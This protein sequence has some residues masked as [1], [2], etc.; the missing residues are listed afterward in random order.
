MAGVLDTSL[1]VAVIGATLIA[2]S[3]V[4][5][6]Y[7]SYL[8]ARDA[9]LDN[10]RRLERRMAED[11]MR[12]ELQQKEMARQEAQTQEALE[13]EAANRR[14]QT[15]LDATDRTYSFD[16]DTACSRRSATT[17]KQLASCLSGGRSTSEMCQSMYG[18]KIPVKDC[19]L[20]KDAANTFNA[21]REK[22]RDHC[23]Q[24]FRA[25]IR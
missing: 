6:Y 24:E 18:E 4:S 19:A 17:A 11:K 7:L 8:P 25:G 15:C 22:D 10:E 16:W 13:K 5:Y 3:A 9:R 12:Q 20:P 2:T 21:R 1:K 23:L 14:Y